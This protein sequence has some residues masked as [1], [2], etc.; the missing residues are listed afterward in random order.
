MSLDRTLAF[1][2]VSAATPAIFAEHARRG[3]AGYLRATVITGTV[4]L[5]LAI[6]ADSPAPVVAAGVVLG[7]LIAGR[8]L[9]RRL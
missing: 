3:G 5:G 6:A 4:A 8:E 2:A 9:S 1:T 7:A